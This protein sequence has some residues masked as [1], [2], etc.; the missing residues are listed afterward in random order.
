MFI[1]SSSLFKGDPKLIAIEVQE[2]EYDLG[3]KKADDD[4]QRD[5][6]IKELE[7]RERIELARIEA[8]KARAKAEEAREE[9]NSRRDKMM[10]AMFGYMQNQIGGVGAVGPAK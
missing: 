7:S 4:W 6:K 1:S 10:E 8:E 3:R 5:F 2:R 9:A